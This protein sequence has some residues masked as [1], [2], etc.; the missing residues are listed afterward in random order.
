MER[1]KAKKPKFRQLKRIGTMALAA[2]IALS[3]PAVSNVVSKVSPLSNIEVSAAEQTNL[4]VNVSSQFTVNHNDSYEHWS[5]VFINGTEIQ[6]DGPEFDLTDLK[7]VVK[8]PDELAHLL[9]DDYV[10]DYLFGRITN[11]GSAQNPFTFTGYAIDEDGEQITI[12]KDEHEPYEHI[13]VNTETNS[14]EFDFTS[15]YSGNKLEPYVR[16]DVLGDYY[17]NNLGF[18]TPIIVPD[19]RILD[20]GTYEF[21]SALVRGSSVDLDNV[22]NAYTEN[23]VIDYSTDPEPE[24]EVDTDQLAALIA[25][26]NTYDAEDYSDESF[27]ALTLAITDAEEVLANEDATQDDVDAASSALQ[28]AIDNLEPAEEPE[29]PEEPEEVNTEALAALLAEAEEYNEE[30]YTEESFEALVTA[31]GEA[32]TVFENENATQ[33]EVDTAVDNLQAA[34]DGLVRA[35]DPEEPEVIDTEALE[36][37]IT[38]AETYDAADYTDE[39]FEALT[40]ALTVAQAVLEDNTAT[41]GDIDIALA[42]L[43][44]AIE[45]LEEAVEPTPEPKPEQVNTTEL[46]AL[47]TEAEDYNADDYT[48]ESF[49]AFTTALEAAE[50]VLANEDATQEEID[51]ALAALET[52]IASLV[53]DEAPTET[54]TEDDEVSIIDEGSDDG[55]EKGEGNVL[56]KTA[57][58]SFN[59]LLVGFLALLTGAGSLL[60]GKR[61]LN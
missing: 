58:S 49:A 14:I 21:K 40:N 28:T 51:A 25:E 10:L 41:Q 47:I 19:T 36:A 52:A 30:D 48:A 23:L 29:E 57:T 33:D 35:E 17:L 5:H 44:I 50:A 39:S 32:F 8:F 7:Y 42:A 11:F 46:E 18:D 22:A 38:E 12:S 59:M 55:A 45:G 1:L 34:I 27:A 53:E 60:L 15:F 13:S 2:T 26:A 43:Q 24:P 16:Q 3:V 56:P 31:A 6:A 9:F 61:K 4:M 54:P 20:N 37:L